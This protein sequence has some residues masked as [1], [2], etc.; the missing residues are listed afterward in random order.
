VKVKMDQLNPVGNEV[1]VIKCTCAG[2]ESGK[3]IFREAFGDT[4]VDDVQVEVVDG[5]PTPALQESDTVP[6]E[7]SARVVEQEENVPDLDLQSMLLPK[8][9][10]QK[11]QVCLSRLQKELRDISLDDHLWGLKS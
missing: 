3:R 5:E 6:S 4:V 8:E 1:H 7:E 9:L 2:L 10:L 11:Y